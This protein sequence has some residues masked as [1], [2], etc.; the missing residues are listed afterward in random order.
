MGGCLPHTKGR[1]E[2]RQDWHF[3]SRSSETR[4]SPRIGTY[5]VH[6]RASHIAFFPWTPDSRNSARGVRGS[7]PRNLPDSP[8][9]SFVCVLGWT[10]EGHLAQESWVS[11]STCVQSYPVSGETEVCM[12]FPALCTDKA[13]Q[14]GPGKCAVSGGFSGADRKQG[15][16]YRCLLRQN[17]RGGWGEDRSRERRRQEP[18]PGKAPALQE[19]R[20]VSC[21]LCW[22]PRDWASHSHTCQGLRTPSPSPKAQRAQGR[23]SR[24]ST[25]G[26]DPSSRSSRST[27]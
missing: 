18:I 21:I 23:V 6:L 27:G 12:P 14:D 11:C 13:E 7:A 8:L 2:P 5:T 25:T 17:T 26:S 1:E 4:S 15:C 20:R 22:K 10:L 9:P 16:V 24:W 3:G 19:T